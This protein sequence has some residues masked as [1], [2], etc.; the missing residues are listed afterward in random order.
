MALSCFP[1]WHF[2]AVKELHMAFWALYILCLLSKDA[3]RLRRCAVDAAPA[4]QAGEILI[5]L[6]SFLLFEEVYFLH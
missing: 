5:F 2:S 4:A 3:I 1:I 6:S